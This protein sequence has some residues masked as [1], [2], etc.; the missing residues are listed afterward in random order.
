MLATDSP[1]YYYCHRVS[2]ARKAWSPVVPIGSRNPWQLLF[3][4]WP[5]YYILEDKYDCKDSFP[6]ITMAGVTSTFVT[7][8][9]IP[10][11]KDVVR[12]EGGGYGIKYKD[13][14]QKVSQRIV[15]S[16]SFYETEPRKDC[17]LVESEQA[18]DCKGKKFRVTL[19][20]KVLGMVHLDA[21]GH[22]E[23][24][25]FVRYFDVIPPIDDVMR[26]LGCV[27]LSWS[28]GGTRPQ[29]FDIV[30]VPSLTGVVPALTIGHVTQ[31]A[32]EKAVHEKIFHFNKL[33]LLIWTIFRVHNFPDLLKNF[34]NKS[35]EI[36]Y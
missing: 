22:P 5:F 4:C 15:P 23:A 12:V 14:L 7:G 33:N 10:T 30:P 11:S 25:A 21:D 13:P 26:R 6:Q 1:D 16:G 24:V 35:G 36:V 20:A 17:V 18:A 34:F 9:F 32:T 2:P 28:G 31:I 8:G 3:F 29:W 27:N 19:E